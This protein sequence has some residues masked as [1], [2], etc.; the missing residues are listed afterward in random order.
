M[1]YEGQEM[2]KRRWRKQKFIDTK[3]QVRFAIE[4]TIYALLFPLLFVVISLIYPIAKQLVGVDRED[5]EPLNAMLT[6]CLEYWWAL[7]LALAL[8]GFISV[9]FSHRIFG[10]MHSFERALLHKKLHPTEP[11]DLELRSD[12]YFHEFSDLLAGCLNGVQ[13]L[14]VSGDSPSPLLS[15]QVVAKRRKDRSDKARDRGPRKRTVEY[16]EEAD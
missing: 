5:L 6:F 9:L 3:Q 8:R 16:V 2:G 11:V 1:G 14:E 10:P 12:D 13:A 4:L 15:H 7:I